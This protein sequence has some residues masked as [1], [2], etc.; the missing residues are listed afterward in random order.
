MK[1]QITD[2]KL[3]KTN[4]SHIP[5][6][7]TY[8]CLLALD[9]LSA[10][11]GFCRAATTTP[12]KPT[13]ITRP[14]PSVTAQAKTDEP[15]QSVP[16]PETPTSRPTCISNGFWCSK[17]SQC[18]PG[19]KVCNGQTD[20]PD[21]ADEAGCSTSPTSH[22]FGGHGA[23]PISDGEIAGIVCGILLCLA[24]VATGGVLWKRMRLASIQKSSNSTYL[25]FNDLD[26]PHAGREN[27]EV[28]SLDRVQSVSDSLI[29]LLMQKRNQYMS[30]YLSVCFICLSVS[31]SVCLF[32]IFCI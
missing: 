10:K 22:P 31:L 26:D 16:S 24:L 15:T 23:S 25:N 5:N 28:Y 27:K 1:I 2:R 17:T 7:S 18:I 21:G 6:F 30:V 8:F 3:S 12:P 19:Y 29:C 32:F 11:E 20:C 9:D 4:K 13:L 14:T